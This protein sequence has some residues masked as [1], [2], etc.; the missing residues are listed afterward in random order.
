MNENKTR[1]SCSEPFGIYIHIPFC[2]VQCD[3]CAFDTHLMDR[4]L[5]LS[6]I[7]A[8]KKEI[9][10]HQT[11]SLLNGRKIS[12]IYFGGGTPSLLKPTTINEIILEIQNIFG[13]TSNCE[14]S[15]E[16]HPLT[17]DLKKLQGFFGAGI[18]RFSLG[19]QALSDQDL[20]SIKRN[21]RA[22]VSFRVF[23]EAR[24]AGFKNIS[25]DLMFG[26][27]GQNLPGWQ[28][29]L[30]SLLQLKPEHISLYALTVEE[31]TP[32]QTEIMSGITGYPQEEVQ[33]KMYDWACGQL[34]KDGFYP[35]E[36]SNFSQPKYESTHNRLYWRRG[37]Y[38][39]IGCS[40]HSS[41]GEHRFSNVKT[42][43]AYEQA[44]TE[45][46]HAVIER[47]TLSTE[48]RFL[49]AMVFG[50]RQYQGISLPQLE[51]RFSFSTPLSI[52]K[53]VEKLQKDGLIFLS[54][55][56]H[57]ETEKTFRLTQRGVHLADEVALHLL[58]HDAHGRN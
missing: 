12:S 51:R 20:L 2:P 56:L 13:C 3:F 37:D 17:V 11:D 44:I 50:L 38:L 55:P 7:T 39:G 1:T 14:I 9:H 24:E 40:A 47:E 27:P 53:C 54:S 35:Y 25:C 43:E 52:R 36:I 58:A 45:K 42:P 6:Y 48:R 46:G 41:L 22:T 34:S 29:T 10:S 28:E 15:L 4:S 33:M 30:E 8:I 31:N 23:K 57:P 5:I 26:L 32:L 16:G 49:E 19:F 18:N 21:H